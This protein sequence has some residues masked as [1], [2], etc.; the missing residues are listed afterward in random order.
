MT[1]LERIRA[2]CQTFIDE[3]AHQ[4][5][6]VGIAGA[7]QAII[8]QGVAEQFLALVSSLPPLID[9]SRI[10]Q[11]ILEGLARYRLG[12]PTGDCLRRVLEGDLFGAMSRADD[13]VLLALP[14]IVTYVR[15]SMPAGCWGSPEAVARWLARV[16]A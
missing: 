10:P 5:D 16:R 14:A 6:E 7:S 13:E 4:T 15:C 8:R 9:R 11:R 2:L 1:D 12:V 3:A